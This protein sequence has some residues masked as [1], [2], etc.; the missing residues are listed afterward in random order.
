M[1]LVNSD[2]KGPR[3]LILRHSSD[4]WLRIWEYINKN[5]KGRPCSSFVLLWLL[6]SSFEEK[7]QSA[8]IFDSCQTWN[9]FPRQLFTCVVPETGWSQTSGR[10][11]GPEELQLAAASPHNELC[12]SKVGWFPIQLF[13]HRCEPVMKN[14]QNIYIYIY[15]ILDFYFYYKICLSQK[16]R[17][18]YHWNKLT[19]RRKDWCLVSS[20]LM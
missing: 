13:P 5:H 7:K 20:Q 9:T 15:I 18:L 6:Y 8:S 1:R 3:K 2:T 16:K 19:Y 12:T 10:Q 14:A 4:I 11:S 17:C